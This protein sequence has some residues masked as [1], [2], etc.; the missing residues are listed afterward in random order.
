MILHV[1]QK[2]VFS[3]SHVKKN[4]LALERLDFFLY[5]LKFQ[6]QISQHH[7]FLTLSSNWCQTSTVILQA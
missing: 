1:A 2:Q 6:S 5:E 7:V 3:Y 4:Q